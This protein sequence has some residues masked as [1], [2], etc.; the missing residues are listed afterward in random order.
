MKWSAEDRSFQKT[1]YHSTRVICNSTACTGNR[2]GFLQQGS[3]SEGHTVI[4]SHQ[5]HCL[6]QTSKASVLF[7]GQCSGPELYPQ[8][9]IK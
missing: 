7:R 2:E 3:A 5:Q 4:H 1:P 6:E 8:V 9:L